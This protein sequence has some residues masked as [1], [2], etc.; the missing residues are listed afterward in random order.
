MQNIDNIELPPNFSKTFPL[1]TV[2]NLKGSNSCLDLVGGRHRDFFCNQLQVIRMSE[3]IK[4]F[5]CDQLLL[6]ARV[7]EC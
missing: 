5:T 3:E 7:S 2:L 4:Q 1:V 6:V